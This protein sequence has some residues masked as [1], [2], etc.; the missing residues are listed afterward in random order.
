VDTRCARS[1]ASA[2]GRSRTPCGTTALRSRRTCRS[3]EA[4]SGRDRAVDPARRTV[5][6]ALGSSAVDEPAPEEQ[7]QAYL[8]FCPTPAGYVL[9]DREGTPESAGARVEVGDRTY[10]VSKLGR[11]P[12]PGDDRVCV[13]LI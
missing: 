12:L 10:E 2:S 6:L 7:A 3:R 1:T 5:V 13:Y 11:S 9:T 4:R 8:L